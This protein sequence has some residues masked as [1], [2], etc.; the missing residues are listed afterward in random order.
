MGRKQLINATLLVICSFL[1][2]FG[3]STKLFLN[4]M[5]I[6]MGAD[7]KPMQH[8]Y[9]CVRKWLISVNKKVVVPLLVGKHEVERELAHGSL[10]AEVRSRQLANED[11]LRQRSDMYD[12]YG[13]TSPPVGGAMM[14][15]ISEGSE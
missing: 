14:A 11:I 12:L 8:Q 9:G 1:L 10:V 7:A 3:G 5:K 13:D 15:A 2:I 6:P 4:I